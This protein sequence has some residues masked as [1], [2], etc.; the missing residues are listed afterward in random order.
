M[1]WIAL[2]HTEL[3]IGERGKN[4]LGVSALLLMCMSI[5]GLFLWWPAGKIKKISRG[6]KIG[7]SAPWK[8]IIFDM[9]RALGIYTSIFLL[10]IAFTG[11]SLVF[12]KTVAEL[13]N[14]LTVSQPR[15]SP[16]FSDP[17]ENIGNSSFT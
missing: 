14:F 2:V 10:I 8:R 3:L 9:H 5:T 7:W 11:V 6:F 4:V 12:N 17:T 16:P 1:G 13:I 15:P